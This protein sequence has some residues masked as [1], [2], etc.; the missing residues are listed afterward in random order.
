ME[1][2]QYE[3]M[4]TDEVIEELEEKNQIIYFNCS[5]LSDIPTTK[6]EKEFNQQKYAL[7]RNDLYTR[8][9]GKG[10]KYIRV[11]ENFSPSKNSKTLESGLSK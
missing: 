10:I 8:G 11:Q 6:P 1:K 5:K 2:A 7:V 9:F 3:L 4:L